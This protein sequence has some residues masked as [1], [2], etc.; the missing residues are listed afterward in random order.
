MTSKVAG[1]PAVLES[2]PLPLA[3]LLCLPRHHGVER[4]RC[5]VGLVCR[6]DKIEGVII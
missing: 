2:L 3:S 4:G 5:G 1:P 6:T